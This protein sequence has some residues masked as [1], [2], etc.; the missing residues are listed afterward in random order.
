MPEPATAADRAIQFCLQ[1]L[2]KPYQWG[3]NGP[4]AFDCSGLMQQAYKSAGIQIPRVARGQAVTGRAVLIKDAVPGDLVFPYINYTHVAMFI[5]N[6]Q[7][8]EAARAGVPIHVVKL[9]G[10]AGGVRRIVEGG[11]AAIN[12]VSVVE[13]GGI[14]RLSPAGDVLDIVKTLTNPKSWASVGLLLTGIVLLGYVAIQVA[15]QEGLL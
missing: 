7:V 15:S 13:P 10:S 5:G 9:Y 8:V 4:D 6:G 14:P 12:D 1:Q 11:G 3:G 2:G